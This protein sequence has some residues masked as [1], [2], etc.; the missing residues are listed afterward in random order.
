MIGL[1]ARIWNQG[2]DRLAA[3][4]MAEQRGKNTPASPYPPSVQP[5]GQTQLAQQPG[6][7]SL[8]WTASHCPEQSRARMMSVF[9]SMMT[10]DAPLHPFNLERK[11]QRSQ[12]V[13]TNQSLVLKLLY[14]QQSQNVILIFIFKTYIISQLTWILLEKE[15]GLDKQ[16]ILPSPQMVKLKVKCKY[17]CVCIY[18]GMYICTHTVYLLKLH[19]KYS[20]K[21]I[22]LEVTPFQQY[23]HHLLYQSY[24]AFQ[25]YYENN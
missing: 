2:G 19:I 14:Q 18:I 25:C 22:I 3:D 24:Q 6:K 1:S 9:E 15:K 8:Q 11:I 13:A 4:N 17:L 16:Y 23:S 12:A 5:I 20:G 7:C 10:Q 21:I